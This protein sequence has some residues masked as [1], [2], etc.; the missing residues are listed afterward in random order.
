[1]KI[2]AR[3]PISFPVIVPF[4]ICAAGQAEAATSRS[5][6]SAAAADKTYVCKVHS[7]GR[8]E[9]TRYLPPAAARRTINEGGYPGP[10][11]TTGDKVSI[12]DG[13]FQTYAQLYPNDK[14]YALGI[15]FPE[16]TLAGLPEMQYDGMNC[17]DINGDGMLDL[18]TPHTPG[19]LIITDECS[20]G[21]GREMDFPLASQDKIAPFKWALINWQAHGH[22]PIGV[23]DR[24]HFDF[25][26]Y[27]QDRIARN[28]IR[29]GPCA[30][31]INCDDFATGQ[32][33]VPT[34]YIHPDFMDVGAVES[35]MGNHLVDVTSPEWHGQTFTETWFFGSYNGKLTFWEPMITKELL[36]SKPNMCKDI[37]L[38]A[39]YQES[40]SYPTKY[41]IRYLA[42][43]K[44]YR[45]SIEGFEERTAE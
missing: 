15:Q 25:H 22:S 21:H 43:R 14:V 27:T 37:K 24:P 42:A 28:F 12:G 7:Q 11:A 19:Q 13:F 26:F 18:N 39:K 2:K 6:E 30:L 5:S 3:A 40:G 32:V 45:I 34:D 41:C 16:S 29:V 20:G 36:E 4:L 9:T 38:P 23:Y 35:R 17:F 10:C 33:P 1:M 31:L 8:R 44:E